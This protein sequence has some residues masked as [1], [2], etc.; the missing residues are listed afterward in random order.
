M[1]QDK[2]EMVINDCS[3]VIQLNFSYIRVILRRVE[4]YEKMDKL[5]EV[6]EDY[7][8]ILEKDLLVY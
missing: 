8:F 2:K 1:K 3:K 7:K 6:L 4:L 5:D